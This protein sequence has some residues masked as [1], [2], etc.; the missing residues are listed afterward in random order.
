MK[1]ITL[2]FIGVMLSG[3]TSSDDAYWLMY[4]T[5]NNCRISKTM[6]IVQ[7]LELDDRGKILVY[8]R[9]LYEWTC[10]SGIFYRTQ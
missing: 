8:Q 1:I 4:V 6:K 7:K 9:P 10:D 2:L 3:C 5:Q